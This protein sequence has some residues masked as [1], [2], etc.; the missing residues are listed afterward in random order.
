MA[1]I[2][3]HSFLSTGAL[4]PS[5]CNWVV[6]LSTAR[7][8]TDDSLSFSYFQKLPAPSPAIFR[9][10]PFFSAVFR[11]SGHLQP[12]SPTHSFPQRSPTRI[13]LWSWGFSSVLIMASWKFNDKNGLRFAIPSCPEILAVSLPGPTGAMNG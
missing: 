5:V 13:C 4:P 8:M 10:I 1:F 3:Y 9:R 12:S 11:R 2:I 6:R 7:M